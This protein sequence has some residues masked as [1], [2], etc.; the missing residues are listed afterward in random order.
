MAEYQF[1]NMRFKLRRASIMFNAAVPDRPQNHNFHV[2]LH[3]KETKHFLVF[4][5][6][7]GDISKGFWARTARKPSRLKAFGPE[8]PKKQRF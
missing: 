7:G 2:C 3:P 5:P 8:G 4:A 1:L 6:D